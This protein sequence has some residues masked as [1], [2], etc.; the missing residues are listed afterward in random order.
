MTL[1]T[2][3]AAIR[4]MKNRDGLSQIIHAAEARDSK[5]SNIENDKERNRLWSK[6]EALDLKVGDMVFIH[7][8]PKSVTKQVRERI[9][10]PNGKPGWRKVAQTFA[11]SGQHTKLWA[12]P[13]TVHEVKPRAKE[14][15]VRVPGSTVD[16]RLSPH[17]CE[18][19]KLSKE[20][21]AAALSA[22]LKDSTFSRITKETL[23]ALAPLL[24][25]KRKKK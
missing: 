15:V 5:L 19:L 20:P 7:T 17:T 11:P 23:R 22:G 18:R 25:G 1:T 9:T 3:L 12:L 14:V 16:H 21:T 2:I 24:T 10:K 8:E 6:I 4:G 13:L